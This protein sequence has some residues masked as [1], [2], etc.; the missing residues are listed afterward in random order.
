M[1]IL[2][3]G[4]SQGT[5]ALAVRAALDKGHEVTAFARS[6]EK[7]GL[8]HPQLQ[9]MV[10]D[11]HRAASVEAA[12]EGQDAVIIT[13]SATSLRAF[14]ENPHY[15]SQGTG[16]A[17][18]AMKKANVKRLVV[19]SAL[20]TGDSRSLMNP[21][22]RA[23]TVGLFLKLPFLDHERQE[24]LVRASGLDW[25]IAR[26]G[27]LTD[28]AARRRYVK[29]TAIERVPSSISRADVA[30]FMVEA[31]EVPTWVGHAVQ[32]GG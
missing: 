28:G 21:I 20:G 32:L 7:L 2:I 26:P 5:G 4:A 12:V 30:D 22:V 19:L 24:E 1:H 10:G 14:K 3:I 31:C 8:K 25:V 11:F 23:L 9:K 15:F 6:P 16:I 13:A 18:A 17:I 27:R 29:K